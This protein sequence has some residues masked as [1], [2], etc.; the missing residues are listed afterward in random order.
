MEPWRN[1]VHVCAEARTIKDGSFFPCPPTSTYYFLVCDEQLWTKLDSSVLD[2]K[3]GGTVIKLNFLHSID[4]GA[5]P[6]CWKCRRAWKQPAQRLQERNLEVNG[7]AAN[8]RWGG[9]WDWVKRHAGQ[10][11]RYHPVLLDSRDHRYEAQHSKE[12]LSMTALRIKLHQWDRSCGRHDK[13]IPGQVQELV[14][15]RLRVLQRVAG[16]HSSG[17]VVWGG[18]KWSPPSCEG[19][20]H[21]GGSYGFL[22]PM[23]PSSRLLARGRSPQKGPRAQALR[24]AWGRGGMFPTK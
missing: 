19:E 18:P 9:L 21:L 1:S 12:D 23:L 11:E 16:I 7:H 17:D 5:P 6:R 4:T 10:D 2:I 24:F 8:K 3:I 14:C 22:G 15:Q 20:R 13:D